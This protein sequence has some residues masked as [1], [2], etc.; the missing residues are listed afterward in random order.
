MEIKDYYTTLGVARTADEKEI[1][2]A[3]RKLAQQ[4][5]PDKNPGN[6]A[7]EQRFKE[8]NEAYTVLSDAD[9]RAKY[10]RFGTQWEQYARSGGRPEDFDW[11]SWRG[12]ATSDPASSARTLTP[13]E[14]ERFFGGAGSFS[15]F[16]DTLFG[17]RRSAGFDPSMMGAP[18]SAAE[19]V[20]QVTLEEAFHG[21]TRVLERSNGTRLEVTVPRGVQ[22]GSKIRMRGAAGQGD[23]LV[24][25]D[26]LADP[27]FTREGDNLRLSLAVDLYTAV[28]G[29][30]VEVPTLDK[31]VVLRIPAGTQNDKV[32]RLRSLGMPHLKH[33]E[34]RGDLLVVVDVQI[35][36]QLSERQ[37]Q[38]F[39]ELRQLQRK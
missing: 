22:S 1:K 13:E 24:S 34:Q 29:G 35:P 6:K 36:T 17:G 39:N 11:G 27:R 37:K 16:F 10:D 26:V 30:E 2:K 5:H 15:N 4:Y 21:T 28:L 3:Y 33:P 31:T 19:T 12:G 23:L 32:F 14:F 8:I 38:L 25:L 18:P 7:A 20:V 9:K